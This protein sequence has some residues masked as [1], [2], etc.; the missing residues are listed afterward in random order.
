MG[1]NRH[2][3][4]GRG[5]GAVIVVDRQGQRL[6][7]A[8]LG[9]GALNRQQRG[10]GEI[11]LALGVAADRAGE[12][13]VAKE[14]QG[15]VVD[16]PG[17]VQEVNLGRGEGE[18]LN[19]V[20]QPSGAR[21][22]AEAARCR[23]PASEELEDASPRGGARGQRSLKHGEFVHIGQQRGRGRID[24][25]NGGFGSEC[26]RGRVVVHGNILSRLTATLEV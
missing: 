15:L 21:N 1:R 9:E 6:Q 13:V 3:G 17:A 22:D 24:R 8:G 18:G 25:G 4:G 10:T 16:D 2:S 12:A 26:G 20:Q 7:D 23:K 11:A 19:G 5:D 14:V